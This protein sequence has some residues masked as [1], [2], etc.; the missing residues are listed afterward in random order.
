[1]NANLFQTN[2]IGGAVA[3]VHFNEY[4]GTF[5]G[6]VWLPKLYDGRKK[7]FFFVA[8]E[9][10]RNANPLGTAPISVPTA[11]ERGGDFS[12]SFTTQTV[13]GKLQRHP[14]QIYD[15]LT[16][17]ASGNRQLFPGNVIPKNGLNP[18]AQNILAYVPL[19]NTTS[20]D[21][22]NAVNNYIPPAV[23]QDKFPVLSI[24][25]DQNWSDTQRSFATI[26]WNSLTE[27][28]GGNFGPSDIASGNFLTRIDK[29]LG[30]DHVWILNTN[31]VLDLRFSITRY[32]ETSRDAGSGFDPTKLG[33]PSSFVSQLP[34]PSFPRI[35]GIAGNFGTGQANS[36][37]NTT[38][39]TW[40]A[41]LTH[42]RGN[43][44]FHY[45][46]E[47]W[48]LQQAGGS[49]GAQPDFD[50]NNSNWT[51]Q[52]NQ[53]SGGPGVGS[54]V[55][56]FLL[57]LP[58]GGNAPLNAQSFYS[59]RYT[60]LFLQDD[61]RAN[62]RLTL[63]FGLRWDYERPVEERY[64]RLTDRFNPTVLNPISGAAQSSYAAILNSRANASNPGVQLLAQLMPTG[65]FKVP[66]QQL[67]AGVNG[68]ARTAVNPDYH[69]WQPR[70]G[71]AYR[72]GK[73]TVLRGGVGRFT[74]A[75]YITGG[76]NGFSRTTS[77]ISTQDNFLTPYDTLGNPFRGGI[78][79]PTGSSLG[80]L[81]NLGS[82]PSWDDPNIGRFYSWEYSLHLQHQI[83]RWLF[84]AGYS[85][86][87][88]YDISWGWNENLP[89]FQLWNQYLSPQFD[90][91]GR[92]L[93]TLAWNLQVP[94][95]FYNL[96]GVT[97]GSIG[98]SK[99]VALNQLVNP[100]PLLGGVTEN[101]PTGS[102]QYDAALGKIEHRFSNG[103]S[104]IAAFTWSKLF[105]DTSFLG[106]QIAGAR[107]EHKLGGEGRPFNFN[108]AP[109]YDI[110]FGRG[111]RFGASVSHWVD[112]LL[113]GWELAGNYNIQSGIP[114]VFG[115]DSFFTGNSVSLSKGQSLSQ[116]F[117]ATQ[118]AP[119]PSKN[120]DI[121]NYPAWTGIQN[122]PG[123]NYKPAPGDSAKN[124]VY[125]DFANYV[126]NYPTRWSNVRTSGVNEANIGLY[127]SFRFTERTR[128]QLR[129]DAFNVFNHPR[130]GAPNT[131]PTSSS[132]GRVPLA[133]QNQARS[134]EL[135]GKFYF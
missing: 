128:L 57:G 69:E 46:G 54:N 48:I 32:E 17:N 53:N 110:P 30:L 44:T 16:V 113:G 71:F 73:N 82:G 6:P 35:T 81:T 27:F 20:E 60:G 116:W 121:A 58:N 85:H 109:V 24:R 127:K 92:P 47:Y 41:N 78:L 99:T 56:S 90:S 40:Q 67:F 42:V 80:P 134:V 22:G 18:I 75:D 66:G 51:R 118:F 19:P 49:L 11:L 135:A 98:S 45:G 9:D 63:N 103:F 84:E 39:Y 129:F 119:F 108:I 25:G 38:Y 123:Y 64:N 95:P 93:D 117:D 14:V 96:P 15:P 104:V 52:N 72:I 125:Q 76:Q 79:Q 7:T 10:S 29:S 115:T 43:H 68:T 107:I 5:G 36:F 65:S 122:L 62:S 33:F 120:T 132:F 133:Q 1:M 34:L 102:N 61:W 13:N 101:R 23:R 31:K 74:Q 3:P 26:R 37:T 28:A 131:D 105:E 97:G 112:A 106:N 130:F 89:S 124:G 88:T 114:V 126:R 12:Q 8:F 2:L 86:N 83:G 87:K 100:I 94:N 4:G 59:Q 111:R 70:V 77:L 50:F 91:K 55:A 21:T